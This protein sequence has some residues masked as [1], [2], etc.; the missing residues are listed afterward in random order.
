MDF[1]TNNA[2]NKRAFNDQ[3]ALLK[4][5]LRGDVISCKTCGKALTINVDEKQGVI[6]VTCKQG[7]CDYLLEIA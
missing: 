1:S 4:K 7:C 2:L 3:K 5:I 6:S